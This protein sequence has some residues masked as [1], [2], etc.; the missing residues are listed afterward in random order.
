M[1]LSRFSRTSLLVGAS[2]CA[3][4][5]VPV[6]AQDDEADSASPTPVIEDD[7][8][9]AGFG[10]GGIV[11]R[12]QRLRGA[13]D[14]EQAPLLELSE[15][16]IA[17][18]GVGSI[19][20]LVAQ[21]SAQTG[22]SRGRGGG[23]Q[24]VILVNGIR[25]G[26]FRELFQYPPEALEKVEV[27]PEEVAQRFGFPPDRRVINLIL[28][29][30]YR[31]AEVEFE[32]EGPSRG[33]N[34]TR[35]QELGFLQITNG[36]RINVN[37]EANDTSLLTEDERDIIQTQGSVSNVVG[38]PA[39]AAFRSLI[40][41]SRNLEGNISWAKAFLDS[42]TAVSAN[43]F[44]Q[45]NDA[46][47][48]QGLNTVLL[49]DASG[50]S[51]LRTFGEE[52]PIEQTIAVDTLS[53][54]GS[55]NT[56]VNAFRLTSTFDAN[57]SESETRF[58]QLFDTSELTDAALTGALAIDG[59]LPT[60]LQTGFDQANRRTIDIG[61][62]T[63][64]RGP[65]ANLPG[66]ELIAT[67]D[68]GLDWDRIE[69]S[70][71]R[72]TIAAQLTRRSLST[73]ANL[74]IPIT[75]RREG[76]AD[77]LGSF[78]LNLQ[79]GFEDLSDFGLLGDYTA[80]LTWAPFDNLDL[81]ATYIFREVAPSLSA[82]GD[83][84]VVNFNLPVF[85]FVNGETVLADVTTGGNPALPAETQRDWK[86]AAN[87][88]LPF[89]SG[90][91][92]QVEYIRNRSDNVVSSFPQVTPEIE[93]A[94]PDRITR[95]AGG[96]LIALDRRQVTFAE[97][98][99]DRLNFSLNLRGS[100]GGGERGGRPGGSSGGGRGGPPPGVSG[101]Q[102]SGGPPGG[103]GPKTGPAGDRRAAFMEFRTR[104]CA[105]DGLEVLTRLATAIANGEDVSA[106]I[107][108]GGSPR[109]VGMVE[110]L[111]GEDGQID[112]ERLAE[113]RTQICSMDPSAMRGPPA[114][115]STD[116]NN[117]RPSGAPGGP[118]AGP[119]G[120]GFA[121]FR[122]LICAD[123]GEAKLRAL[124][125]RIER[126][127]DVSDTIPGF[128][129]NMAGFMIDRLR[130]DDGELSSERI[131]GLKGRFCNAEGEADAQSGS[132]SGASSSGGPPAGGF[133]P[134]ARGNFSGF[135]YFVSL[136]H[137]IELD[138]EILIAPGLAPLDQLDGQ[139]TSAFG[140]PRHTSRLEAG[141]FG[142]GV[143]VR[144]SGRYTGSTRLDGSGLPG[145]SAIFFDNLATF[146]LRI[147]G[148]ID[149][150]TGSNS[151][152]LKNVRVS[153]RAD[154]IFDGQLRVVDENGDTPVNFQPF[155][156]DPVGRFIGIDIR[157]LF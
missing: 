2:V 57:L 3:L 27:F 141:L 53:T 16:E 133:N 1:N 115:I 60:S 97:T 24:P 54:S 137:T 44:Y 125:A 145:S 151:A 35:E 67:F 128:D 6:Y 72:S 157:K 85:D 96:T 135:R 34:Y 37:F 99:A 84:Q 12:G 106:I 30:N 52:T 46:R 112:P 110:R 120:E 108:G 134:L 32:F 102:P 38:D 92:F 154:N 77:A 105:D 121:A 10:A 116:A 107:P 91:R 75:S 39:Q 140:L 25:P 130:G 56:P 17:A 122:T 126:G 63:T 138:N 21:I 118:P 41:D 79:A 87:W 152:I 9:E 82:L 31:N 153:L 104:I 59:P 95:D 20:D 117:A 131:A 150:L 93:A 8:E 147:F 33:G 127:E 129:P 55:V 28:K 143:G 7:E 49:T 101:R 14:V 70:D 155:L 36:A 83:P 113:M 90:A 156:I 65:V 66:G 80:G 123:D 100:I 48:L 51:A 81:S 58:D 47:A 94:F 114:G 76:F 136:N 43:L 5:T 19:A 78:T 68:L 98:R 23:G 119:M 103:T 42:G 69:S 149:E 29:D 74:S 132:S 146:D 71:T 64:L 11:V 22:S 124:V 89:W 142:K 88:E 62:L 109:L 40:S 45:R 26:S 111:K 73:G 50:N 4:M 139:A 144:V 61:S 86:F 15:A 18:E 13:L 148:N